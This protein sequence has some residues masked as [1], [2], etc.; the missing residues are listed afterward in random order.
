MKKKG[1]FLPLEVRGEGGRGEGIRAT[2]EKVQQEIIQGI[3]EKI[4]WEREKRIG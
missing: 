2:G 1:F 3:M 4:T